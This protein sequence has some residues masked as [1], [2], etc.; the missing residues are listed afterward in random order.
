MSFDG[1]PALRGHIM[2]YSMDLMVTE[3]TAFGEMTLLA[4][5]MVLQL[6]AGRGVHGPLF[7]VI[8]GKVLGPNIACPYDA[9]LLMVW[10]S[11]ITLS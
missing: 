9:M 10:C 3:I 6:R 11:A 5:T 7:I 1:L 4:L 8:F 2:Q